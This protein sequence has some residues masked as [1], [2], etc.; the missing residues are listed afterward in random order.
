MIFGYC[1]QAALAPLV[2][3]RAAEADQNTRDNAEVVVNLAIIAVLITAPVGCV[4]IAMTAPKL[5]EHNSS[6]EIIEAVEEEFPNGGGLDPAESTFEMIIAD[7]RKSLKA[8]PE[9]AVPAQ[10]SKPETEAP[11]RKSISGVQSAKTVT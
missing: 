3:T 2:L 6:P 4:L 8:D 11:R 5:L 1:Q 9:A 10:G 7:R